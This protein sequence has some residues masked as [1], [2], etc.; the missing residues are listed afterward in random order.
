MAKIGC[1]ASHHY[2]SKI[3]E[4][5]NI[6]FRFIWGNKPEKVARNHTKLP[7]KMGGLG[8]IDLKDFWLSFRFSWFRRLS[9]TDAFWPNILCNTISTMVGHSVDSN[10]ILEIITILYAYQ[11]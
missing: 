4:I 5:E 7:E 3:K 10:T 11:P 8:M 2:S 9:K 1:G 6:F